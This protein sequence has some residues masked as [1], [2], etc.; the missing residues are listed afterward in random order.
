M[1]ELV[2]G[3]AEGALGR[4]GADM[5]LVEDALLPGAAAPAGRRA[6]DRP[7]GSID[8][9]RSV[10]VLGLEAGGGIGHRE[11]VLEPEAVAGA[12][13]RRPRPWPRA[14]RPRRPII[15][16]GSLPSIS[17]RDDLLLGRP[18]AKEDAVLLQARPER[19]RADKS[20]RGGI[21][22]AEKRWAEVWIACHWS[23]PC[24]VGPDNAAPAP[25]FRRRRRLIRNVS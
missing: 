3:G 5:E 20:R 18:E 8:L 10:H 14:S 21:G 7:A 13:R 22:S 24:S 11:A 23:P 15:A 1:V 25:R 6:T 12:G 16:I 2:D 4:E 9:A 17:R 19:Q